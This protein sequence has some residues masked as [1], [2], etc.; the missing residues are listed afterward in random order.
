MRH[1]TVSICV[2]S[3]VVF[4]G[5]CDILHQ[6]R[7]VSITFRH[8]E[9]KAVYDDAEMFS[10]VD[11]VIC[12]PLAMPPRTVLD[13]KHKLAGD[14]VPFIVFYHSALPSGYV[15]AYDGALS[16]YD[17]EATINST[18][19]SALKYNVDAENRQEL[20]SREKEV[21]IGVVKG[22]S[23]KEI[24]SEI[25]VSVNTVMTHR[26]NIA[27]KLQIHSPAGLTI[28]ALVSKLVNLEDVSSQI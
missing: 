12:D 17:N 2:P 11:L 28:Y 8:I 21:V 16:V 1:V 20:T 7:D 26:R 24:A 4:N 3:V 9:A 18:V 10:E 13:I 5:L 14:A 23:N 25:N 15:S 22:L 27:S 19:L 6:I